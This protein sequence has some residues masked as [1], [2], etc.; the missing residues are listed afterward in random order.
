MSVHMSVHMFHP[1]LNSCIIDLACLH[2]CAYKL[3]CTASRARS[4][5][6]CSCFMQV[7]VYMLTYIC[8][9]VLLR[10]MLCKEGIPAQVLMFCE[11]IQAFL[12]RLA[13]MVPSHLPSAPRSLCCAM[14]AVLFTTCRAMA[15]RAVLCCAVS[16][17]IM[18][19]C[20]LSYHVVPCLA[21]P[22]LVL[23]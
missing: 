9:P 19:F 3:A 18:P 10:H 6:L 22:C 16:T 13:P 5:V 2:T 17:H 14:S 7:C 1:V 8:R 21:V 12:S 20:A 11:A 15:Y 4:T 23:P